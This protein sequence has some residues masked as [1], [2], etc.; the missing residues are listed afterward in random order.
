MKEKELERIADSFKK[1]AVV[2]FWMW[3]DKLEKETLLHQLREIKTKG[4]N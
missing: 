2:P 1:E 3:N 4:M